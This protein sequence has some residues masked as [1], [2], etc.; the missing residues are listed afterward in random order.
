MLIFSILSLLH[1]CVWSWRDRNHCK[2]CPHLPSCSVSPWPFWGPVKRNSEPR[3]QREIM[4]P[5]EWALSWGLSLERPELS[6]LFRSALSLGLVLSASEIELESGEG[7]GKRLPEW[8]ECD[9][10]SQNLCHMQLW[11]CC[12]HR[13][14][15]SACEWWVFLL[16][17]HFLTD[18]CLSWAPGLH[19][20]RLVVL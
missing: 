4:F 18:F 14:I 9:P 1:K 7:T 5:W 2:E 16:L 6:W 11:L 8:P 10:N 3:P 17:G 20:Q 19:Y 15:L 12:W 13:T